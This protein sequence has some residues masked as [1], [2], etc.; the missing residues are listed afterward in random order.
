ME[1]MLARQPRRI[2]NVIRLLGH[3]ATP[4]GAHCYAKAP[5]TMFTAVLGLELVGTGVATFALAP[6]AASDTNRRPP[7]RP[8]VSDEQ[9][10]FYALLLFERDPPL[11]ALNLLRIS[12]GVNNALPAE[13]WAVGWGG[14]LNATGKRVW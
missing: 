5:L 2:I 8:E 4:N 7:A 6:L 9:R 10:A 11:A 3:N 14:R 12:A 1:P 13:S